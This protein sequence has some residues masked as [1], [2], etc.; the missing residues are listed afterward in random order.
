MLESSGWSGCVV[1]SESIARAFDT[2]VTADR[3][4]SLHL[5][6]AAAYVRNEC[7]Q[8]FT[9]LRRNVHTS[10]VYKWVTNRCV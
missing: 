10:N 1:S 3:Q 9:L 4:I 7:F 8:G 2:T 5:L 6:I